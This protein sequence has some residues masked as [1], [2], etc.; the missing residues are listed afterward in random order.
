[1]A[2]GVKAL[3]A[4]EAKDIGIAGMGHDQAAAEGATLGDY[5]FNA[6]KTGKKGKPNDIKIS[7]LDQESLSPHEVQSFDHGLVQAKAQNL[8]RSLMETPSN[9]MTPKLFVE[10][11]IKETGDLGV[12]SQRL[13]V[14]V[15][16]QSWAEEQKMGA[17]LSVAKGSDEPLKFLEIQYHGGK[18]GD[19]P[20]AL[21]GKGVTFDS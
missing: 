5:K 19:R 11:F 3:K 20:L 4:Q 2:T 18:M 10:R 17:F 12:D 7:S 6:F 15:R 1:M 21:V 16:D 9:H 13:R 14:L 8:A